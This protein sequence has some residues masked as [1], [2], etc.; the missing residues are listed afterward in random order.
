MKNDY[1]T[2]KNEI[3]INKEELR[4][5]KQKKV[6]TINTTEKNW[7]FM[8]KNCL[9][10]KNNIGNM[11]KKKFHAFKVMPQ[12]ISQIFFYHKWQS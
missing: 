7:T 3:R 6:A 4:R 11:T 9:Q 5:Q 1:E 2:S 8:Q 10:D 12:N